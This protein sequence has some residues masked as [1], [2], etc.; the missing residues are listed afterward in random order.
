M[1]DDRTILPFHQSE[2]IDDPLTEI[3]REGARRSPACVTHT[4]SVT[5]L[6]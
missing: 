2:K 5:F 1:K 6:R 3:T 4:V